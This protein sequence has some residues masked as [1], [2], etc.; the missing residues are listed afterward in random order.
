M[1]SNYIDNFEIFD[2]EGTAG[3]SLSMIDSQRFSD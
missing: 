3:W 1:K 2:S